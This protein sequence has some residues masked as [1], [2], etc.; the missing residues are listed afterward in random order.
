MCYFFPSISIYGS[1]L[2]LLYILDMLCFSGKHL[3]ALVSLPL[4]ISSK[5]A[6]FLGVSFYGFLLSIVISYEKAI[7]EKAN[8][9]HQLCMD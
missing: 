3:L 7:R 6:I 5:V 1:C 4:F 9:V 8:S 2:H